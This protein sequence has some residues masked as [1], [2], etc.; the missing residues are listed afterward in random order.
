MPRDCVANADVIVTLP[1][2]TLI[3]PICTLSREKLTA[4]ELAIKFALAL[5]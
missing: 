1:K 5:P 2:K 4:L 3:D